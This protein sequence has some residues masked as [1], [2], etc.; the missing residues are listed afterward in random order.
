MRS[1]TKKWAEEK[2]HS[3][4]EPISDRA[5][6]IIR[7]ADKS[8]NWSDME[9]AGTRLTLAGI[10]DQV[11]EE[12]QKNCQGTDVTG[13]QSLSQGKQAEAYEKFGRIMFDSFLECLL[14]GTL[15][16]DAEASAKIAVTCGLLKY[17]P[18]DPEKHSD[19]PNAEEYEAGD[20]IYYL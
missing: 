3:R 13:D 19:I 4:D 17:G 8:I 9:S 15:D 16:L 1:L 6:A 12:E 2:R 11:T 10:I 14:E 7:E 18:Y 5:Y 20:L